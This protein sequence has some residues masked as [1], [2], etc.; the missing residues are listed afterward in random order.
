MPEPILI[1]IAAALAGRGVGSLYELVK[2][3]LAAR[4][5]AVA[6]LEAAKDKPE[7]SAE[8]SALAAQLAAA[9]DAD[10][11]F[12]DQLVATW[13]AAQVEQNA[14]TGSVTNNVSGDVS[15]SVVQ[16]RDIHGDISFG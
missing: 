5:A 10:P 7:D 12:G 2:N 13:N 15:G 16:T 1:S 3:K 9:T 14:S 6:A 8:V 4:P 11:A